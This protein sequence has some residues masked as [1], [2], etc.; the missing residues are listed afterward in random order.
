M[1]HEGSL[2]CLRQET[3]VSPPLV[4][5]V[6]PHTLGQLVRTQATTLLQGEDIEGT[7]CM[8]SCARAVLNLPAQHILAPLPAPLY[9]GLQASRARVSLPSP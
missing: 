2:G 5:H 6:K 4:N 1:H 7:K 3:N 9:L 8:Q